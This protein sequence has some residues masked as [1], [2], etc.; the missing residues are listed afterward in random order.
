MLISRVLEK[1]PYGMK[2]HRNIIL[3]KF[4]SIRKDNL[5]VLGQR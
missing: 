2:P 5:V 1:V 3:G 4:L